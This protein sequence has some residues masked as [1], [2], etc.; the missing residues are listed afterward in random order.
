MLT[1]QFLP[2]GSASA[3]PLQS[4]IPVG[5]DLSDN[6]NLQTLDRAGRTVD[7]YLWID[8]AG[9]DSDQKAWVDAGTYAIV[10][11][12]TFAPGA[13]LWITGS[14]E[15]QA[16]QSSGEV[17]LKDVS[18]TLREGATGMGNPF[19]ISI[20]LQDILP[21][22]EDLS[23]NVNIQTLD[24][25]GRTVDNYLWIDWAGEDSDQKAWVDAGTYAIVDGV[26]FAPGAGL[27]VTGTS[28]KQA[29]CFPAPE[30]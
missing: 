1:S 3:M 24:R 4:I 25:A 6:V 19:P 9:E 8:W 12:V 13:G 29:I 26:T 30:L 18:I 20:G 5:D 10:E 23:D 16:I 14:G 27:W 11:G 17:G 22:G 28:D 21:T 7:N 2:V 15:T